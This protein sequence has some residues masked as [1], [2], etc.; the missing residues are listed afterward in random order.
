MGTPKE[1][2]KT[3]N[4]LPFSE[5]TK[6]VM[7]FAKEETQ[8]VNHDYI[9]TGELL[10]GLLK[11]QPIE[12]TFVQLNI[13]TNKI[14]EYVRRDIGRGK[15]RVEKSEVKLSFETQLIIYLANNEAE[16]SGRQEITPVDLLIGIVGEADG[17]GAAALESVGLNNDNVSSFRKTYMETK[18]I[19]ER[20]KI[21]ISKSGA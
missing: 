20:V 8:R 10:L 12:D 16:E 18:K 6:Q 13:S 3:P 7:Q 1:R 11:H 17:I 19:D 5:S 21:L 9:G 15:P 4:Q 2:E 14:T